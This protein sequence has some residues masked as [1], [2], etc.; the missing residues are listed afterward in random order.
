MTDVTITATHSEEAGTWDLTIGDCFIG[1]L[2]RVGDDDHYMFT[3]TF[4]H[5]VN[6][7][8]AANPNEAMQEICELFE[9]ATK[10]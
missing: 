8:E 6:L 10:H 1:I 4:G 3:D 7:D 5:L 9:N 2:E